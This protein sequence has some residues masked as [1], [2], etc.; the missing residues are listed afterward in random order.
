[1]G[2]RQRRVLVSD[3]AGERASRQLDQV[4]TVPAGARR[5][6][7]RAVEV[8]LR[9]G[10]VVVAAA[11]DVA[12]HVLERHLLREDLHAL[13]VV[14][15]GEQAASDE[16][17]EA[18]ERVALV[19]ESH[20]VHE[21]LHRVRGHDHG[22]VALGVGGLEGIAAHDHPRLAREQ[23]VARDPVDR[24]RILPVGVGY[25]FRHRS[26]AIATRSSRPAASSSSREFC[27]RW[28]RTE[29]ISAR[30]RPS[31]KTTKRKPYFCS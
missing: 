16:L 30:G 25:R 13:H 7:A 11:H 21:V 5:D 1:M 23:A 9:D 4:E 6:D 20:R 8:E 29:R 24:D 10:E 28:R 14:V 27:R 2:L 31:T 22:V 18:L 26:S 3:K 17:D 12:A 19:L 15:A